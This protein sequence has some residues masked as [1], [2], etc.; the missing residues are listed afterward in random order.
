MLTGP[1]LS[2]QKETSAPP[3]SQQPAIK[4]EISLL[5]LSIVIANRKALILK[6]ITVCAVLGVVVSFLLPIRYSATVTILP[7]QQNSSLSSALASQLGNLGGM[8]ALTGGNFGLKSQ[9]DMFVGM[10]RS[11]SVE[12]AMVKNYRLM[13]EYRSKYPS[14]ARLLLERRVNI[15][16]SG[17]DGLIH[18]TIEDSNSAR[19]AELANGY[20]E[21]F[22]SLSEHLAITEAAQRRFFFQ[23]QLDEAKE[24]LATA[25]EDLKKTEQQT[26]LIQ[27]DSQARALIES[28]ASLRAQIAAKEVQIEALRTYATNENS[29]LVLAEQELSG[30]RAQLA[31]L[32]GSQDNGDESLIVPKGKVPEAGLLYVRKLR[33]VKYR[34]TIFEILA[35]QFELAKLDE[36]R[37]GA[38]IQV[39]DAAVPPE[40]RTSPKR[41][42]IVL[43]ASAL[44]LILG[45]V[46]AMISEGWERLRDDTETN[47][48]LHLLRKAMTFRA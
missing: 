3:P 28:A 18:L 31:R 9:N 21:Q 8:A 39:V 5:D 24:N 37:E 2:E 34:E 46:L 33:E 10:L 45:I 1:S 35:R 42:L 7:P 36:A 40:R 25:E 27:L 26:G 16:G 17:K 41:T 11:R 23:Q 20:I 44:G 12:D 43:V 29:Q 6:T 32:G 15:D 13:D 19:A 14:D 22:R 30:L 48:K 4:E 47:R 38:L